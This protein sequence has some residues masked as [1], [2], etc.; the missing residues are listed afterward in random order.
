MQFSNVR[1]RRS[2]V[3]L[4]EV[5]VA[6][7][8]ASI[9]LLALLALFPVGALSMKQ[10]LK[11]S[12]CAQSAANAMALF[13]S[14]RV[15]LDTSLS[16][17]TVLTDPF[18]DGI[19]NTPAGLSLGLG[20]RSGLSANVSSYPVYV[21]PLGRTIKTLNDLGT[22]AHLPVY[23][24]TSANAYPRIIRTGVS[25]VQTATPPQ[26]LFSVYE[27]WFSLLDD[28][29]FDPASPGQPASNGISFTRDPR[30]T[31]AYMLRRPYVSNPST[32]DV[33]IVVYSGRPINGVMSSFEEMACNKVG[34]G[35]D[36]T[37]GIA[38]SPTTVTILYGA[39]GVQ[40]QRPFI[41]AG[42]WILDATMP[43]A[44]NPNAVAQGYFYRV[45]D[46]SDNGTSLTLE[47]QTP[48]RQQ[49]AQGMAVFLDNVVEVFEKGTVSLQ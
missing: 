31:F 9:G 11:D 29:I 32:F 25:F 14:M 2:G 43:D 4:I 44:T 7:F 22:S 49:I 23:Q 13:K 10:A 35:M 17:S 48:V 16:T 6:I 46:V 24:D 12:R 34:F 27:K 40:P 18:A 1:L 15:G 8:V 39:S 5:L 33:T 21:D 3:T 45:V 38:T 19:P 26:T 42:G 41:K 37:T 36:P 30:Y 47:L 28:I 20:S